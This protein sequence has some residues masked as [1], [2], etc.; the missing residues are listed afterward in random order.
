[1]LAQVTKILF[2]D[3]AVIQK[4]PEKVTIVKLLN[5]GKIGDHLHL[6]EFLYAKDHAQLQKLLT[7]AIRGM[8]ANAAAFP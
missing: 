3:E 2:S 1:M 8:T 7:D 5:E 4:Y 6:H